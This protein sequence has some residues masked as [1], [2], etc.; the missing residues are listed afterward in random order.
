[1]AVDARAWRRRV[2][3]VPAVEQLL[4]T[5]KELRPDQVSGFIEAVLVDWSG[6]EDHPDFPIRLDLPA[7]EAFDLGFIN[8]D[9][10][11]RAMAEAR[12]ATIEE[13]ARIVGSLPDHLQHHR[14]ELSQ[15]M[16]SA[17]VF[18][19]LADR[20]D[21]KFTAVKATWMWPGRTVAE[22]ILAGTRA[23]AVRWLAGWAYKTSTRMLQ[24]AMEQAWNEAF[25]H[26][27]ETYWLPVP[28]TTPSV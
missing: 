13:M 21:I 23:E 24:R 5:A 15:A 3:P 28:P 12:T 9:E 16:G 8:A 17:R 27:P 10:R 7:H 18:G 6:E 4:A 19:H 14:V 1:M 20:L 26:R 25:E 2:V 22:E 11:Q